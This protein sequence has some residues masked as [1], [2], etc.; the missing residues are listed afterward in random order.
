MGRIAPLS[1]SSMILSMA[2]FAYGARGVFLLSVMACVQAET[3]PEPAATP[4]PLSVARAELLR[5]GWIPRETY[6][7]F[8]DGLRWNEDGDA[9]ALYEA[10]F[11]EVE[12]C[13]STA[14]RYCSFNYVRSGKC[15][16]LHTQG[17]FEVGRHEPVVVRRSHVCPRPDIASPSKA[18]SSM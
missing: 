15:L 8:P 2:K 1:M 7:A 11:K 6:G 18:A 17:R 3:P 16:S 9:G 14:V 5:D 12:A 10:G 4:I 13:S